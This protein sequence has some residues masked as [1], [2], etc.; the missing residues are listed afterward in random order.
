MPPPVDNSENDDLV[1]SGS[2][3]HSVWES[4]ENGTAHLAV[5]LRKTEGSHGDGCA[6]FCDLID[7]LLPQPG[8]LRVVPIPGRSQFRL[9]LRADDQ[10]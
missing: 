1:R 2:E 10:T 9:R 6:G 7:E 8:S 3:E 4:P 5:H